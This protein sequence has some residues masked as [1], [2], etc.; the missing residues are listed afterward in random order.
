MVHWTESL[1]VES[2]ELFSQEFDSRLERAGEEVDD[3]LEL[4]AKEYDLEP[5]RV[6]DV[7][8]GIGRHVVPFA[9]SDVEAHGVDISSTFLERAR[10]R[11]KEDGVDDRVTVFE[12]D[13][14]R[15]DET[16]PLE[17]PYDLAV[18]LWTSFGYYDE[19]TD[20][21]F[22]RT[23]ADLLTPDGVLVLEMIDKEGVLADFDDGAVWTTDDRVYAEQ[24]DYDPLTSRIRSTRWVLD[25]EGQLLGTY[26]V[27]LRC[28][29]PVELR[30]LLEDA[31][32][33]EIALFSSLSGEEVT[34]E[35]TRLVATARTAIDTGE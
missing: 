15:L 7:P 10:E 32:F 23:L 20:R 4:V 2:P 21:R 25:D 16:A 3:I 11:A 30:S 1:F 27:D 35:S 22:L 6:L 8:C 9:E 33:E 34:R 14:R 13:V 12:G 24:H 26:E 5:T 29:A 28:Y 17:G 18:N 19:K 31:G